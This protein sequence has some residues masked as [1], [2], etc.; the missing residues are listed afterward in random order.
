MKL[1]KYQEE[2]LDWLQHG[3]GNATCNAVAGS[4][5]ST[6]LRYAAEALERSGVSPNRIKVCV[7]NKSAEQDLKAKFG[8]S[9]RRSI[10]T[11]HSAGFTILKEGLGIDKGKKIPDIPKNKYRRI[12]E[13]MELIASR[14]KGGRITGSL[15]S[16]EAIE[17]DDDFLKVVDLLRLTLEPPTSDSVLYFRSH[18]ELPDLYEPQTIARAAKRVIEEGERMAEKEY[19]FDFTDMIYL[20]VTWEFETEPY[21]FVLV[22]ECQDLNRCQLELT[23]MMVGNRGR[24]LY[25]GDPYQ[26]IYGF[27]GADCRSYQN[28]VERIKA[29]E[30]PLS[31]CYRCP[32]NHIALVRSVFPN[33]PIEAF[34]EDDG[35]LLSIKDG[36]LSDNP[37]KWVKEDDLI[38]SRKTAP[39]VSLC[40]KLIS[41]G[42]PAKVKGREI[43]YQLKNLLTE[44]DKLRYPYEDLI[45]SLVDY[46]DIKVQAYK[47]RDNEEEL[48]EQL[49]DKIQAIQAIY[50]ANP[51]SKSYE[52]LG[53]CIDEIFD[54]K[55]SPIT[56]ST[57]HRAKGLEAD[58][59]FIINPK[60]MPM[61]WK[62]QQDWQYQ[63][64]RNILYVALT[65]AK[66][67]L[68]ICGSPSWMPKEEEN[69][70]ETEQDCNPL[71][72][73][74]QREPEALVDNGDEELEEEDLHDVEAIKR[75]IN[76]LT[77]IDRCRLLLDL[78]NEVN[79]ERERRVKSAILSYPGKSDRAIARELGFTTNVTVS[80]I[81]KQMKAEADTL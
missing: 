18:F 10:S 55:R 25:V 62:N 26:A 52:T 6:T 46:I 12:A 11:I 76:N 48:I 65:R 22:D 29:T 44:F 69:E 15:K 45:K 47:G 71:A 40:I 31:L 20:P 32:P 9:W 35:E 28:I 34:R 3:K 81:R 64:E 58:R 33:I 27:A 70:T 37:E 36:E 7:F 41:K 60:D 50:S 39:L 80:R 78:T 51:Q 38:L 66:N 42:Y 57:V 49:T 30:L 75:A 24:S 79:D 8:A 5:K 67:E 54:D 4:G 74:T 59:V 14:R 19:L 21:D 2:I 17:N 61:T 63:Q 13:D 1:S 43:A 53:Q 68:Y 16:A 73:T 56:L 77:F 23:R 72:P